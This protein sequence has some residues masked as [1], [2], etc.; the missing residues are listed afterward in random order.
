MTTTS[1]L[2]INLKLVCKKLNEIEKKEY[3]FHF[4]GMK[5]YSSFQDSK[6]GGKGHRNMIFRVLNMNKKN[7]YS[8]LCRFNFVIQIPSFKLICSFW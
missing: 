7:R 6:K 3:I 5:D 1:I 8:I 2:S 4:Y